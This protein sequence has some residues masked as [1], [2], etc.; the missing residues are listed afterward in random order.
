MMTIHWSQMIEN[1]TGISHK[2]SHYIGNAIQV[3]LKIG[4]KV[5]VKKGSRSFDDYVIEDVGNKRRVEEAR[6]KYE[7]I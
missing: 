1:R 3:K 7:V 6:E 2:K 5:T 4:V